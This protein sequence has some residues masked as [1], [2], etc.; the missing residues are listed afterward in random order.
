MQTTEYSLKEKIFSTIS[1]R[2]ILLGFV[3]FLIGSITFLF[4]YFFAFYG[5]LL[6]LFAITPEKVPTFALHIIVSVLSLIMTLSLSK[7]TFDWITTK[8]NPFTKEKFTF[9]HH[10][11]FSTIFLLAI[12]IS[13]IYFWNIIGLILGIT[14]LWLGRPIIWRILGFISLS[15]SIGAMTYI[16][17]FEWR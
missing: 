9:F 1:P 16:F 8:S 3:I 15:A 5:F 4:C 13:S 7:L 6:Y 10:S 2:N 12:L 11:L 17:I 14:I